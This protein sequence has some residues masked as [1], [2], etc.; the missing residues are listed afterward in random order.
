MSTGSENG[1]LPRS[2]A[3]VVAVD[4]VVY[5]RHVDWYTHRSLSL[6]VVCL[7]VMIRMSTSR[8]EKKGGSNH[9]YGRN[10]ASRNVNEEANCSVES[11]FR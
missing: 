10:G 11:V 1:A 2:P 5:S 4:I 8:K 9:L 7:F 6:C 3:V